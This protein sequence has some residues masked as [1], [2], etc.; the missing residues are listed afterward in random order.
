MVLIYQVQ[1]HHHLESA[2]Q[3]QTLLDAA[4]AEEMKMLA[5]AAVGQSPHGQGWAVDIDY[6]S[7]S[8]RVDEK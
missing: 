1:L 3:Q 8:K 2:E 4:T 6:Y 7:K 5:P